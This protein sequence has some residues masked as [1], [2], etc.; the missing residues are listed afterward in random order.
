MRDAELSDIDEDEDEETASA[1]GKENQDPTKGQ[2]LRASRSYMLKNCSFQTKSNSDASSEGSLPVNFVKAVHVDEDMGCE[3]RGGGVRLSAG[4][5]KRLSAESAPGGSSI[6]DI[7]PFGGSEDRLETGDGITDC[8]MGN[9]GAAEPGRDGLSASPI[10]PIAIQPA[11]TASSTLKKV[12][13]IKDANR[14][15][16]AESSCQPYQSDSGFSSDYRSDVSMKSTGSR[17]RHRRDPTA[18][19]TGSPP[20]QEGVRTVESVGDSLQGSADKSNVNIPPVAAVR[21]TLS[22]YP[23]TMPPTPPPTYEPLSAESASFDHHGGQNASK[24]WNSSTQSPFQD[25]PNFSRP[26]HSPSKPRDSDDHVYGNPVSSPGYGTRPDYLSQPYAFNSTAHF[27]DSTTRRDFSGY[28]AP[29]FDVYN[30]PEHGKKDA[31]FYVGYGSG[32]PFPPSPPPPPPGD[33]SFDFSHIG[34]THAEGPAF[35]RERKFAQTATPQRHSWRLYDEGDVD[36]YERG[37]YEWRD[38][39]TTVHRVDRSQVPNSGNRITILSIREI[40]SDEELSE[41]GV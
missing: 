2:K 35:K 17:G 3:S 4:S 25:I 31:S 27:S 28:E 9:T 26:Y 37:D 1:P 40:K 5:C 11:N 41:K 22:G 38:G 14:P 34:E 8:E 13:W 19:S 12:H 23:Y 6:L 10:I 36:D 33:S 20:E 39:Q 15:I 21:Q 16:T 18:F 24:H 29:D 7:E 30:S 32:C